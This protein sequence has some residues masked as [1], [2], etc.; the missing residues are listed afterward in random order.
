MD[1]LAFHVFVLFFL[2]LVTEGDRISALVVFWELTPLKGRP[3]IITMVSIWFA[4]LVVLLLNRSFFEESEKTKRP[5]KATATAE[6]PFCRDFDFL[7]FY[8]TSNGGS[9]IRKDQEER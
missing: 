6:F 4:E 3:S 8:S 1:K 5:G 9:S 2:L 7:N